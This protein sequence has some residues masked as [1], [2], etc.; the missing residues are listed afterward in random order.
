MFFKEA[1]QN[2]SIGAEEE[3][4]L[5]RLLLF[6][7]LQ[8][9]KIIWKKR[10][11]WNTELVEIVRTYATSSLSAK[12]RHCAK[13]ATTTQDRIDARKKLTPI[14]YLKAYPRFYY[15]EF[16]SGISSLNGMDVCA[17]WPASY[18]HSCA[19]SVE[20]MQSGIIISRDGAGERVAMNYWDIGEYDRTGRCE[21]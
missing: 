16:Y 17:E 11:A 10:K 2:E 21:S 18:V 12:F 8:F 9:P 19:Q 3:E 14:R 7:L 20:R 4:N 6:I 13:R 5:R 15:C 1:S